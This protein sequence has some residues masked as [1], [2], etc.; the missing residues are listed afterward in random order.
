MINATTNCDACFRDLPESHFLDIEEMALCR[1]CH[2]YPPAR[3]EAEPLSPDQLAIVQCGIEDKEECR[4]NELH[5]RRQLWRTKRWPTDD[6]LVET[7]DPEPGVCDFCGYRN[8][9]LENGELCCTRSIGP[10]EGY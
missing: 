8:D 7:S 5:I 4:I 10:P 9:D 3:Q 2:D 6:E 1:E